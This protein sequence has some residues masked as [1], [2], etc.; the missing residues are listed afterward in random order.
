MGRG[1]RK[2]FHPRA[3]AAARARLACHQHH[4]AE[5]DD[6]NDNLISNSE[7]CDWTGGVDYEPSDC[8]DW[9]D[10]DLDSD[11]E[12]DFEDME[13]QELLLSLAE[14]EQSIQKDLDAVLK[15]NA[16]DKINETQLTTKEWAKAEKKRGFGYT[17]NSLR[18]KQRND[19]KARKKA[20]DNAELRK[21]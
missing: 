10:D 8:S 4:P 14:L 18:T 13:G 17:G 15:P 12:A 19:Q 16:I 3:A 11:S 9:V 6:D 7:D 1:R 5:A 21:T 20:E 2:T